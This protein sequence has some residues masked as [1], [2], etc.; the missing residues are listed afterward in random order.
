MGTE[1]FVHVVDPPFVFTGG[2]T[3]LLQW[4]YARKKGEF[5]FNWKLNKNI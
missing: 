5:N 1:T 2:S 3:F 4:I